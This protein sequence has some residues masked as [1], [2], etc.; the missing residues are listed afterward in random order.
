MPNAKK[1]TIDLHAFHDVNANFTIYIPPWTEINGQG[2]NEIE[3]RIEH[4]AH[5]EVKNNVAS[6]P[7][8]IS[9]PV[10]NSL[11]TQCANKYQSCDSNSI[12]S[13]SQFIKRKRSSKCAIDIKIGEIFD[14]RFLK[15]GAD[16][17]TLVV[18]NSLQ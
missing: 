15:S 17:A 13:V 2:A 12:Y 6:I 11:V 1:I 10:I 16:L 8:S 18:A 9:A 7:N 14:D 5:E 3:N 4:Y